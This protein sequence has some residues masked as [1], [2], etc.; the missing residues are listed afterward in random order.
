MSATTQ[1]SLGIAVEQ[2]VTALLRTPH[3]PGDAEPSDLTTFQAI[4]LATLVDEGPQR[5]RALASCLGTTDATACRNVDVLEVRG[6]ACR[7]ADATDGRGTIVGATKEGTKAVRERRARLDRH[8][9]GLVEELGPVDGAHLTNLLAQL[10]ELFGDS[11]SS[12]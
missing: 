12:R 8:V 7:R 9:A 1:V 5:L 6:L 3:L 2:L 10:G 4:V 11:R